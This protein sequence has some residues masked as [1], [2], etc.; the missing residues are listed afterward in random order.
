[1]TLLSRLSLKLLL[2]AL[3]HTYRCMAHAGL[4]GS[5]LRLLSSE[6]KSIDRY[7][8]PATCCETVTSTLIDV[9]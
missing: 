4:T 5:R 1:M 7:L 9:N 6:H 8:P 3:Q 2:L